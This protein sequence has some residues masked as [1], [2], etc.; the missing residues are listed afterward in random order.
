MGHESLSR[1]GQSRWVIQME[2][3][4]VMEKLRP[5]VHVKS[6]QIAAF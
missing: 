4:R 5:E 2:G 3:I 1:D 6:G